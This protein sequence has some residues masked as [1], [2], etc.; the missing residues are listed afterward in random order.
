MEISLSYT[1]GFRFIII[2][3]SIDNCYDCKIL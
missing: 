2:P 1:I 3:F